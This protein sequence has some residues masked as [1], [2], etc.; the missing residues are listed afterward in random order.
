MAIALW[1]DGNEFSAG[2]TNLFS[3]L[4]QSIQLCGTI[5]SPKASEEVD[6]EGAIFKEVRE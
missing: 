1:A 5:G 2:F 3:D 4:I 6:D